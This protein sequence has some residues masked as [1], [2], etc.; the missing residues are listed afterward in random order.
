MP[1]ETQR[2][3]S[4]LTTILTMIGVAVGLG[5]VWRFPYMMGSY[6]GSAFLFVYLAFTIFFAV[7]ALMAELSLG[8]ES[9][10][11]TVP[12]F[13]H[14]FGGTWGK[15]IGMLLMISVFIAGTYYAVVVS[16]VIFTAGFSLVRGFEEDTIPAYDHL[17]SRGWMQFGFTCLL[18][19]AACFVVYKGLR[20]GVET[21]EQI[22]R[23]DFLV[24]DHLSHHLCPRP[25]RRSGKT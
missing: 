1:R 18:I 21:G 14:A 6:G 25:P 4:S 2:Y 22:L 9:R 24:D 16:N 15:R 11:S 5:N 13:M 3:R 23:T 20:K 12:A 8:R 10:G 7:P 19:S 17:L